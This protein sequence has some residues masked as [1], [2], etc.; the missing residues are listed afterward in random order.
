M[1]Q[2]DL[3]VF[4]CTTLLSNKLLCLLLTQNFTSMH[5]NIYVERKLCTKMHLALIFKLTLISKPTSLFKVNLGMFL[6]LD[7]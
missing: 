3:A 5:R 6:Y 4:S 7:Q 2:I 1:L